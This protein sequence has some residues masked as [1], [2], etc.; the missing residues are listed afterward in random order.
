MQALA[1]KATATELA[2]ATE[3]AGKVIQTETSCWVGVCLV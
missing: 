1:G 2:I 3:L